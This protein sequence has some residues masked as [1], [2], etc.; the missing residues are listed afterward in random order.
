MAKKLRVN[1]DAGTV[2]VDVVGKSPKAPQTEAY[3]IMREG[4]WVE[5]K[6]FPPSRIVS[7]EVLNDIGA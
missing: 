4:F 7:I 5:N 6:L 1:Y 2:D 3:Y